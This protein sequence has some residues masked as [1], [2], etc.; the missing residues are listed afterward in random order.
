MKINKN[1]YH[2][3][4]KICI[5]LIFLT[6]SFDIFLT[7]DLFHF[8]IRF[9]QIISVVVFPL[10]LLDA[11]HQKIRLP[12][13]GYYLIIWTVL[14]FLFVFRSPDIANAAGYFAWLIFD[15]LIIFVVVQYS[16]RIFSL[17]WLVTVYLGSFEFVATF[18]LV[19]FALHPLGI[20]IL[21]QQSWGANLAR[22]NGFCYEPSYY[23]TYLLPGFIIYAYLYEKHNEEIF[24]YKKI[25]KGLIL[26][27]LALI[28]SSSRMG[29]LFMA[30]YVVCRCIINFH[31]FIKEGFS[32]KKILTILAVVL[33]VTAL[34][35]WIIKSV[36]LSDLQFLLQGLGLFNDAAHSR[37]DRVRSLIECVNVFLESPFLGYSLGGVDPVLVARQNNSYL[38]GDN[39]RGNSLGEILAGNGIIGLVPFVG[40]V[41]L[42]VF[43]R[44]ANRSSPKPCLYKALIW[45]FVFEIGILSLNQNILRVYVWC[46]IAVLSAVEYHY[47]YN[48]SRA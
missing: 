21:V 13:G 25:K 3:L 28:L 43:G 1:L 38:A 5:T 39:G 18:G 45:A 14:Q 9:C 16:D 24:T 29:W 7:F 34:V 47:T 41:F 20:D 44:K 36:S 31:I 37:N 27:S 26:I 33:F 15:V 2:S 42:L 22:I 4:I 10:W 48:K 46:L 30:L 12:I 6:S 11:I 32:E 19:Q 23:S 35:I 17:K 8:N 40:Y